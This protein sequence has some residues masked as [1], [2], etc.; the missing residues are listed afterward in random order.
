VHHQV[1]RRLAQLAGAGEPAMLLVVERLVPPE[2]GG[3]E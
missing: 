3:L 1:V 2:P